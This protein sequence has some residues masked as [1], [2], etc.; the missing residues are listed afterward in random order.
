MRI[1]HDQ[2]IA[3][4]PTTVWELTTDI[5]RWP[6]LT[7]T[8]ITGVERL[9]DGP[10]A[11]GSRARLRQP[12]QRPRVW[13]VVDLDAP[14]RFVWEARLG[15]VRMRAEHHIDAV[16]G[17]CRYRLVLELRGFGSRLVGSVLGAQFRKVL[18]TEN[19]CFA[20]AAEQG[21]QPGQGPTRVPVDRRA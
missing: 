20:H 21:G 13:T 10:L 4:P 2:I 3:A 14:R 9:D 15:T 8:T 17:G 6:A 7:P 11:V 1:D 18:R 5:E 12:K 19:A 16:D